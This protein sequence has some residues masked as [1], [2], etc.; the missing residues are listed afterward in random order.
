MPKE[1]K[2]KF[3][4]KLGFKDI[5]ELAKLLGPACLYKWWFRE[6]LRRYSGDLTRSEYRALMEAGRSRRIPRVRDWGD[7]E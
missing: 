7:D 6:W 3:P 1:L 5:L 4:F 2:Q